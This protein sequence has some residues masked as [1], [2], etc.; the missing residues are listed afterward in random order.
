MGLS[1][2]MD[3]PMGL[4][5]TMPAVAACG[6]VI[7]RPKRYKPRNVLPVERGFTSSKRASQRCGVEVRRSVSRYLSLSRADVIL[8]PHVTYDYD[9][10]TCLVTYD[11]DNG[12]T[13]GDGKHKEKSTKPSM[14]H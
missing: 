12:S 8:C 6:R 14:F 2:Q 10:G 7:P 5:Y 3:G 9:N 1:I 13:G 4:A 11:Y